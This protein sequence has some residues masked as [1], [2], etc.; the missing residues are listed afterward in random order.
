M[1][2]SYI[3]CEEDFNLFYRLHD[4]VSLEE[5]DYKGKQVMRT[6]MEEGYAEI[7]VVLNPYFGRQDN[8]RYLPYMDDRRI[9]FYDNM[10]YYFESYQE[11]EEHGNRA[12]P[13]CDFFP[14]IMCLLPKRQHG[15]QFLIFTFVSHTL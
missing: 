15:N 12:M 8:R 6:Y 3:L 2:K 9:Y 10:G 11:L 1:Y 13:R 7:F 5:L 4:A 14:K